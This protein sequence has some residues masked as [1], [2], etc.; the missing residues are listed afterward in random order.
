MT[1]ELLRALAEVPPVGPVRWPDGPDL[2]AEVMA[3]GL[4]ASPAGGRTFAGVLRLA[5]DRADTLAALAGE[6]YAAGAY[7]GQHDEPEA[8]ALVWD[9]ADAVTAALNLA[10]PQSGGTR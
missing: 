6:L 9:L 10:K 1:N 3:A 4:L 7:L 5:L 8:A 2:R